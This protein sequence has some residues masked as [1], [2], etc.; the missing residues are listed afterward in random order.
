TLLNGA[1]HTVL[2]LVLRKYNP[3][4]L[5]GLLLFIPFSFYALSKCMAILPK[6]DFTNGL[7]VAALGT[8]MIPLGIWVT[9][10][11]KR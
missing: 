3:G 9:N 6:A 7:V 2:F 1:L 10:L 8:A 5:T 11:T 4:F